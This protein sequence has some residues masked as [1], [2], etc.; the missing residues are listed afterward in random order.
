MKYL[1]MMVIACGMVLAAN[2]VM[3]GSSCCP[4]SGKK[5]EAVKKGCDADQMAKCA[6]TFDKLS[7]SDEQK[8]KIADLE[9]QCKEE[10]SEESCKKYMSKMRDV[11]SDDQKATFD[12]MIAQVEDKPSSDS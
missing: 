11:L 2:N 1:W 8:A 3:A 12:K 6:S 10:G 9:K 5:A 4:V 7:L